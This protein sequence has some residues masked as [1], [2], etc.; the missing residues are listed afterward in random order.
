MT[1]PLKRKI[2]F[3]FSKTILVFSMWSFLTSRFSSGVIYIAHFIHSL[4]LFYIWQSIIVFIDF[5]L[6]YS[7]HFSNVKINL[8]AD[9]IL[10]SAYNSQV[11]NRVFFYRCTLEFIIQ[12]INKNIKR[13]WAQ[14]WL[15]YA[16]LEV[17]SKCVVYLPDS[18]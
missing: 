3:Y 9:L 15:L 16:P 1:F 12:V 10:P 8:N 18:D 11:T 4:F 17:A 6:G 2:S 7:E 14:D 13:N 5:D